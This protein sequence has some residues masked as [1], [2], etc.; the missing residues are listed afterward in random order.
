MHK[1][2]SAQAYEHNAITFLRGRDQSLI[3]S[4]TVEQWC[5]DLP[6]GSQGIELACGGGYPIT[7]ALDRQRLQLWAVDSSPTLVATFQSRF[8]HIPIQCARVQ[9]CDFFNRTYHFAIAIG[10][11]FLLPKADQIDLI[12]RIS[13][14]L[15]SD[16]R[17]LLTAPVE[18]GNWFDNNTGLKCESLGQVAYEQIFIEAGFEVVS[19]YTDKGANNYYD[20]RKSGSP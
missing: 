3:G 7:Q 9:D 1:E 6:D 17:F 12:S 4:K 15:K 20:L 19:T 18:K 13:G 16:A 8:P 14:I 11:L 5:H 2:D 10:L